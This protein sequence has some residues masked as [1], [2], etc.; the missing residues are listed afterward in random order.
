MNVL[1]ILTERGFVKQSTHPGPLSEQL[2]KPTVFYVGFDATADSLHIGSLLPIIVMAHLRQAGHH[3]IALIG[4]GTTMIGD[5]SFKTE[6]RPMLTT[7]TIGGYA[8]LIG[9]QVKKILDRVDGPPVRVVDNGEWLLKLNYIDFLREVGAQFSVN[10]MLTFECFKTR[11]E[12]GLSFLEFNYM[13]LQSYDFLTLFRRYGCKLQIGGDDQWAN[14]ISGADLIRRIEG[15]AAY[16][17]THPL[18]ETASG[19]KMGKTEAGAIWLDPNR[20]SPY[21]FYQY[22]RNTHDDDV[23]CFLK[24]FTFLPLVKIENALSQGINYAKEL[25][26]IEVTKLVHG[27]KAA[28]EAH[29]AALALFTGAQAGGAIPS[30]TI[31]MVRLVAGIPL[32]ELLIECGLVSSKSEGRRLVEQGGLYLNSE[33]VGDFDFVVNDD[34]LQDGIIALRKGKKVHHHVLCG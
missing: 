34:C 25:L 10:R 18:L 11:M 3:P 28:Q 31:E 32:L 1:Q 20:T 16:G 21:E 8:Q 14:I 15:E 7:D 6:M 19:V 22:W 27:E 17:L 9:A 24:L 5:P 12:R 2:N 33:K 13:L 30:T 4:G 23:A 29:R 26:A